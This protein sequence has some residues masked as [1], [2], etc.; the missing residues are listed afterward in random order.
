MFKLLLKFDCV[1]FQ[2]RDAMTP[3]TCLNF[4][5]LR[6]TILAKLSL[7][8]LVNFHVFND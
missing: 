8:D 7:F 2:G 1:G 6:V 3:T 4:I 5:L